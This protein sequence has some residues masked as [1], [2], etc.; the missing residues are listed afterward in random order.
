MDGK[1]TISDLRVPLKRIVLQS[2]QQQLM[3]ARLLARHCVKTR[4]REGLEENDPDPAPKRQAF[5]N[6][7][8][9]EL[10]DSLMFYP[11]ANPVVDEIRMELSQALGKNLEFTYPPGD[12]LRLVLRESGEVRPLTD[13]EQR[14]A[15]KVLKEITGQKVDEET[16]RKPSATR[17]ND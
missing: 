12:R 4:L 7:I 3:S 8:A 17:A 2:Y 13:D 5:V 16:L 10:F 9:G 6:K 1:K 14:A 15:L 11:N